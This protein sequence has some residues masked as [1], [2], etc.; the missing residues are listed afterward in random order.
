LYVLRTRKFLAINK[1]PHDIC[2]F[3][4]DKD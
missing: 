1:K 2:G 4:G 3:S